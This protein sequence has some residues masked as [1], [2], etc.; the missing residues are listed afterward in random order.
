MNV[1]Y[2][3]TLRKAQK[4][5]ESYRDLIARIGGY[6]DC[7][8]RLSREMQAGVLLRTAHGV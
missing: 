7:F 8:V 2:N 6:S 5:P 4:A 1:V 3:E